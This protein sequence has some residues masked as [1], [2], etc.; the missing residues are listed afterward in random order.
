[1]V[2]RIK[3][4][5]HPR[6][7]L[8]AR[9]RTRTVTMPPAYE[10]SG[11]TVTATE[12][13]ELAAIALGAST[14]GP[15]ALSSVLSAIAP[16]FT[17]PILVILHIDAPFATAFADWL[18]HQCGHR[19][20]LATDGERLAEAAG[21]VLVA[22]AE[23]HT[24]VQHGRVR[25]VDTAPRNHC[26]PSIDVLFESLAAELG[27]N[28]AAALLTGMGRDGARGLLA[29]RAA[30]G[31]TFAQDEATSTIYGM[32][33]EAVALAAVDRAQ[34]LGEIAQTIDQLAHPPARA[35]P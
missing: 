17:L 33:R 27:T 34:P 19:V 21:A 26:R 3:V 16:R 10:L 28:I 24:I 20:R 29:I 5:T 6:G 1:M 22:P 14:G 2:A 18:A 32:P 13:R 7:R 30:G 23:R 15:G 8:S 9:Q 31:L 12:S 35:K 11:A 4:I 25:L